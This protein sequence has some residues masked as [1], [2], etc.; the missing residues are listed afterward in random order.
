MWHRKISRQKAKCLKRDVS[1]KNKHA[2]KG[3]ASNEKIKTK[4]L[5]K[6]DVTKRSR[7]K[8]KCD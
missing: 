6:K 2:G 8:V 4:N 3:L 7:Q 1:Q 5:N